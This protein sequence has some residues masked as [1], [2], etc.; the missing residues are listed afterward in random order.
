MAYRFLRYPDGKAKA[1]TFSYDDGVRQ[2]LRLAEICS[3]YGIKCTFNLCKVTGQSKLSAE[4]I[5]KNMLDAGHEI[6]VHGYNHN[7]PGN[8]TDIEIVNDVLDCRK[9]LE[10]TFNRIVRGMAYPDCGITVV[11]QTRYAQIKRI[12]QGL[13]IVYSRTLRGD[14]NDFR[15]PNDFHAWMPTAHH[16]NPKVIEWAKEFANLDVNTLYHSAHHPRLFYLW[17]HSYE[18]DNDNNWELIE[19][20]CGILGQ[21]DDTWY[22]TNMEIYEYVSAWNA[23]AFNAEGTRVYNPTAADVWFVADKKDYCVKSGCTLDLV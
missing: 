3:R 8:C 19:N 2:D 13:G 7:A 12:L 18:F 14:N 16:I 22:A 20:L 5:Q 6:A 10:T 11:D 21:K 9:N 17:G 1:V 23:L 15:L 4:D